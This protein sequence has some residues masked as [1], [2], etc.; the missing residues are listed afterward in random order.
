MGPALVMD[1]D[2]AM[3]NM[4]KVKE[5]TS[6]KVSLVKAGGSKRAMDKVEQ[7]EIV[8]ASAVEKVKDLDQAI[9]VNRESSVGEAE[10]AST[11][12][13]R[14]A[15]AQV[16]IHLFHKIFINSFGYYVSFR[17]DQTKNIQHTYLTTST[18]F[19][20]LRSLTPYPH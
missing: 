12:R 18:H 20:S 15:R 1:L 2:Q 7:E 3:E 8:D 4:K 9:S 5:E 13:G 11:S 17:A 14:R 10:E 16:S 19:A 6:K